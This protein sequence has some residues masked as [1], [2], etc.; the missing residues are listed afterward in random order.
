[1]HRAQH[2]INLLRNE[3]LDYYSN[4]RIST[5]LLELRNLALVA[6]LII[7]SALSRHESRGLHFCLDYPEKSVVAN[8]TILQPGSRAQE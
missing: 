8:D 3:I 4:Y 2:R 5:P 1:L 6:E 7:E